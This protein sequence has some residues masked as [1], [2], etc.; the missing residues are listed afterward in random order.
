MKNQ[1]FIPDPYEFL[2]S[3][4]L[5]CVEC[6]IFTQTATEFCEHCGSRYS[7]RKA[8]LKDVRN[9]NKSPPIIP[10]KPSLDISQLHSPLQ[11]GL[12][13]DMRLFLSNHRFFCRSC[14]K[15][16]VRNLGGCENCG[17]QGSLRKSTM[18]DIVK[19]NEMCEQYIQKQSKVKEE[20]SIPLPDV[21]HLELKE[22]KANLCPTCG[23]EIPDTKDRFCINCGAHLKKIPPEI[24]QEEK[25]KP[26][27]TEVWKTRIKTKE[28]E[29]E[30]PKIATTPHEELKPIPKIPE[31]KE[32]I[33]KPTHI[34]CRFCGLKL[35]LTE[36]FCYQCG[37][38]MK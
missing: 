36:K 23:H 12:V 18:G 1:P 8:K 6:K 10:S 11:F 16:S 5:F 29:E 13:R 32:E 27:P 34:I 3:K 25:I 26:I 38:I 22:L 7:L 15:F 14:K 28:K 2:K 35:D 9:Y 31:K 20:P 33:P 37:T 21:S 24:E 4:P 19:Y 30:K 17:T